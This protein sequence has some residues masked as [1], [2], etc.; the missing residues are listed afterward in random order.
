MGPLLKPVTMRR[1][2]A[3]CVALGSALGLI[4]A[5]QTGSPGMSAARAFS[6]T[7]ASIPHGMGV[8]RDNSTPHVPAVNLIV[9]AQDD[10]DFSPSPEN[11]TAPIAVHSPTQVEPGSQLT[12]SSAA[13][14][15]GVGTSLV[16]QH[17]QLQI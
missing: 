14:E 8:S 6:Q 17:V 4:L 9:V 16:S 15:Y 13:S 12:L 3:R 7:G 1:F 5:G 2:A 11:G 10:D